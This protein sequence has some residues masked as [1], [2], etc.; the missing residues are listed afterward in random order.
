MRLWEDLDLR[1]MIDSTE[2]E[3]FI[4][5]APPIWHLYTGQTLLQSALVT[6][7]IKHIDITP[8]AFRFL[9]VAKT[10]D[11][12][13]LQFSASSVIERMPL[14]GRVRT[15][16]AEYRSEYGSLALASVVSGVKWGYRRAVTGDLTFSERTLA[17]TTQ[18]LGSLNGWDIGV[19]HCERANRA[20]QEIILHTTLLGS[21][22]S[23]WHLTP[24]RQLAWQ[25]HRETARAGLSIPQDE[26]PEIHWMGP[27]RREK[28]GY[29]RSRTFSRAIGIED[30]LFLRLDHPSDVK[31]M[32]RGEYLA[33]TDHLCLS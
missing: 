24:L 29:F 26:M 1:M 3:T 17:T 13:P 2:G 28:V 21:R 7:S 23:S 10:T 15:L 22:D 9:F 18:T 14:F 5:Y 4:P 27:V 19:V 20:K 6:L 25:P 12:Q 30:C 16:L 8:V 31:V 11:Q 33:M 32:T